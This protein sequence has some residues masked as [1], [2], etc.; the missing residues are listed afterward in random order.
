MRSDEQ[1]QKT[2]E[3]VVVA[4]KEGS[5]CDMAL[6]LA[7]LATTYRNCHPTGQD[8]AFGW[9]DQPKY[10][11]TIKVPSVS[12]F[13]LIQRG[14]GVSAYIAKYNATDIPKAQ[15]Q[16]QRYELPFRLGHR[17]PFNPCRLRV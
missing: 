4:E 15:T 11:L 2:Y 14:T 13:S 9:Y 12:S 17:Q 8:L 1:V 10:R 7:Y 5:S 6:K 3:S 16:S